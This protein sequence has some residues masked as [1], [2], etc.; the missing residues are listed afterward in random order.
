MKFAYRQSLK[1]A[2]LSL[3]CLSTRPLSPRP[4]SGVP[5]GDWWGGGG[6]LLAF[7]R[8]FNWVGDALFSIG[9]LTYLRLWHAFANQP[10]AANDK[11]KKKTQEL[12]EPNIALQAGLVQ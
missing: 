5:I 4:F 11:L 7:P 2:W 3:P 6:R 8:P 10:D 12:V 9:P 1:P